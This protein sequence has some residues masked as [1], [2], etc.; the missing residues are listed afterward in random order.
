MTR[1]R[2]FFG[3]EPDGPAY[4]ALLRASVGTATVAYLIVRDSIELKESARHAMARLGSW[5]T[6]KEAVT[7]WPGTRLYGHVATRHQY[8]VSDAFIDALEVIA[9]RLY[10]WE[11]PDLP[12]DLGFLRP[13]GSVWLGVIA[14]EREAFMD[15][16]EAEYED[17]RSVAPGLHS[18]LERDTNE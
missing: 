8:P 15:L 11:Q 3:A 18:L 16:S 10:A 12:E 1:T 7:E 4:R 13:D 17:L 14:H 2:W 5:E 6:S 9:D